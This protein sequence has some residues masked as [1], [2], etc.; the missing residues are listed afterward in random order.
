MSA[1]DTRGFTIAEVLVA[2]IV[3]S[4]GVMAL[5]GSSAMAARMIGQGKQTTYVGQVAEARLDYLRQLAAT[6]SPTCGAADFKTDSAT[7]NGVREVWKV[8]AASV[9]NTRVVEVIIRH[10][11]SRRLVSDTLRTTILCK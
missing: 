1:N 2:I 8:P 3:L 9:N 7:T 4:V 10:R 11:T 6:T 5:A